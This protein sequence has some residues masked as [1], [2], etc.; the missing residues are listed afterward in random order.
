M[1]MESYKVFYTHIFLQVLIFILRLLQGARKQAVYLQIISDKLI[2][3]TL[4][5]D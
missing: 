3:C 1:N 5:L 2:A 4:E